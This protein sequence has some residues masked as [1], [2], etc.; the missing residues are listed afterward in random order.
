MVSVMVMTP[1]HMHHGGADLQVIGL[2]ISLHILG[3]FAFSPVV[4]LAVDRYGGRRCAV[5]GSGVL[6]VAG[7]LAALAPEGFSAG[8]AAGLFLLGLGWS[9]TLISGSTLVTQAVPL[10]ERPG[11]QGASDLVM[12]LAGGGG[13]ALAGVVVGSLG[14]QDL[15]V[16]AAVLATL[17]TVAALGPLRARVGSPV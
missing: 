2:V 16:G 6:L 13:G 15:G 5:A 12:G 3:M 17:V 10:G 4:G 9:V 14:Y 1:L 11:V 8:L 7:V